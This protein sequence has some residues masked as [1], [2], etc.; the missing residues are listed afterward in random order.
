MTP[1]QLADRINNR[2]LGLPLSENEIAMAKKNGLIVV[3]CD[4][5]TLYLIGAERQQF[6]I[7][8]SRIIY[9]DE[10]TLEI[11]EDGE[12]FISI[13][14]D[15]PDA[16]WDITTNFIPSANY[17]IIDNGRVFCN[18]IVIKP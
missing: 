7:H 3:Y 15:T 17:R 10:L 1:K 11:S 5:D 18:A 6:S 8:E 13:M 16:A 2:P 9:Y 12:L 14:K 4:D